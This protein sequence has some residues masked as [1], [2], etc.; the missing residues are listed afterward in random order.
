MAMITR[1]HAFAVG[2]A[3]LA[4]LDALWALVLLDIPGANVIRV[5]L[6][7]SPAMAAFLT[8]YLT[9]SGSFL[10]GATQGTSAALLSIISM[11]IY[12]SFGFRHDKIGGPAETFILLWLWCTA[13]SIAGSALAVII[14]AVSEV[15]LRRRL[16]HKQFSATY[17]R[18]AGL[19][20]VTFFVLS[21]GFLG[22]MGDYVYERLG[23]SRDFAL[24]CL[25]LIPTIIGGLSTFSSEQNKLLSLG[26]LVLFL[27]IF[28]A[29]AHSL[30]WSTGQLHK[31]F[32]SH[33][34][35]MFSA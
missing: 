10:L 18:L 34:S 22:S 23:I 11:S 2:L 7:L 17:F 25:W 4:A 8:A 31:G 9:P 19:L 13:M 28:G 24:L 15:A 6:M 30:G 3:V 16:E 5:G 26:L 29:L 14:K 20:L 12:E 27:C 1:L 33:P 35:R 21:A 32:S